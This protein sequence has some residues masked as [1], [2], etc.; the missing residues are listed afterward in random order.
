MIHVDTLSLLPDRFMTLQDVGE[1]LLNTDLSFN[2]FLFQH[3]VTP[4]LFIGANEWVSRVR[5]LYKKRLRF[6]SRDALG[7]ITGIG[8]ELSYGTAY[9]L[10]SISVISTQPRHF[11]SFSAILRMQTTSSNTSKQHSPA[12]SHP[13]CYSS[14]NQASGKWIFSLNL[15]GVSVRAFTRLTECETI[16]SARYRCL[17]RIT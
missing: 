1:F 8:R 3:G 11:Q 6:W 10:K 13:M 16:S 9:T 12:S 7:T 15:E 14:A 2:E 4:E 17:C 5:I